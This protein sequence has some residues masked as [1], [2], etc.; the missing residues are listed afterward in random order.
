MHPSDRIRSGAAGKSKP[1]SVSAS[2]GKTNMTKL[3]GDIAA[4]GDGFP[5]KTAARQRPY[6][7]STPSP[8]D[9]G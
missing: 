4:S 5:V 8:A 3:A 7:G 1:I 6:R 9:I 2:T